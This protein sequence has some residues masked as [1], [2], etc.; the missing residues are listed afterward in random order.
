M[1]H[2][3]HYYMQNSLIKR[4]EIAYPSIRFEEDNLTVQK[5]TTCLHDKVRAVNFEMHNSDFEFWLEPLQWKS[6]LTRV[7][8]VKIRVA[9]LETHITRIS[10][11]KIRVANFE[12]YT[13]RI[14]A[15]KIRVTN[16][17]IEQLGFL[18]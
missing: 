5:V 10:T 12:T 14:F 3:T 16:F 7:F 13:T 6:D 2:N 17:E 1:Y 4:N 15:V 18:Q 9:N 8:A 11:V